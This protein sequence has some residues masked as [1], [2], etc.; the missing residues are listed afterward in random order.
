MAAIEQ[1]SLLVDPSADGS[2][3]LKY[4]PFV[5][6]LR[7]VSILAVVGFHV[8]IPGI[9]GGFV[10]VDIFFVISGFLI[11]NQIKSGLASGRFSVWTF[12]AQ[13]AL[14]IVPPYLIMLFA[15]YALAPIFLPST[16][17]AWDF[18]SSAI[19][20][21]LM[22]S[23]VAFLFSQGYFDIEAI[24]KALLHTW[25]LAV[26]EQFYLVAPILLLL[27]FRLN[28]RR[29]GGLVFIIGAVLAA[30]A[31]L[32]AIIE[33]TAS[34]RNPAFYLPVWR[35]WE[36]LA[37]GFV[38][39][40]LASASRQL[41]RAVLECI[42][43]GGVCCVV[44]ALV[45]LKSTDP[46][47]SDYAT[48]PVVGATAIIVCGMARPESLVARFLSLRWMVAI[49]L[50]SYGW[51]LWHWPLL[52]FLRISRLDEPSITLD[53]VVG[54]LIPL[55]LAC[56]SYRFVERPITRWRRAPGNVEHPVRVV[57]AVTVASLATGAIG[58]LSVLAHY[59][60]TKSFLASRYGIEGRGTLDNGCESKGSFADKCFEGPLGVIIGD[61]HATVLVGTLAER[62]SALGLP[63]VSVARGACHPLLLAK[64]QRA[65]ERRDDCV[66]L[67]APFERLL[68]RPDPVAFA[69]I[70]AFW[71]NDDQLS[72]R[73][74]AFMSEFSPRT[75]ILLIGPVPTFPNSSL[76][77][78]VL[79]DRF[80]GNRDRCVRP[81]SEVDDTAA[82]II[83]ILESV[84]GQFSNARYLDAIDVFCD[85]NTCRPFDGDVVLYSDSHHLSPA[86]VDRLFDS[87][88]AVLQ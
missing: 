72:A 4:Q 70:T 20:A 5:D 26:E 82:P 75:K 73:L 33:T 86:G 23:N 78:V 45:G 40:Q 41:P 63:I 25:T 32:G 7:A 16:T 88:E 79:S 11:I 76:E 69:V 58:A 3:Q 53:T 43:L 65:P 55:G 46:Y 10:G 42:G 14:R 85:R 64:S 80:L 77:C 38:G 57:L 9:P 56:L 24:E 44:A 8:R 60:S 62:F 67:I 22:V 54:G 48:L 36:F 39:V 30:L 68:A 84:A 34:G 66:R 35:A 2:V 87:D 13:R 27:V 15:T 83:R 17:T 1:Q 52:S 50:V 18:L 12:Y 47:P 6:G 61:S 71:N 59:S 37:G 19:T 74:S 49:G 29:F 81:R 21:P 28:N 31:L 51:Y